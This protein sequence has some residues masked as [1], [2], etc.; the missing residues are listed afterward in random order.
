MTKITQAEIFSLL[1]PT[2]KQ[3]ELFRAALA[4]RKQRVITEV[5][6]VEDQ[7]FSRRI[8]WGLLKQSYQTHLAADAKEAWSM[9]LMFAPDVVFLDIELPDIDGHRLFQFLKAI[10]PEAYIVMVT[11]NNYALDVATAIENG[12]KGFIVKPYNKE[13]IIG[14]IAKFQQQPK[15]SS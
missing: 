2:P 9:Y 7:L 1:Q 4:F 11:A 6:V 5:L 15:S 14:A 10:D 12:A 13:K 3:I 8:L